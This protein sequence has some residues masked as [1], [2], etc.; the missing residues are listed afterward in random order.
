ML[1]PIAMELIKI[2]CT[3]QRKSC[4]R[5]YVCKSPVEADF[6]S[7]VK[8]KWPENKFDLTGFLKRSKQLGKHFTLLYL[9]WLT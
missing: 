6:T 9:K 1:Y 8:F 4:L 5:L 7:I 3:P 2:Q